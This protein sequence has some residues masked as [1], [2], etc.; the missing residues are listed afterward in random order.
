MQKIT[1]NKPKLLHKLN[2]KQASVKNLEESKLL[3]DKAEDAKLAKK[4][5]KDVEKQKKV[6][7]LAREKQIKRAQS[8]AEAQARMASVGPN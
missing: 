1:K 4:L 8:D 5:S 2:H 3:K 6:E 7:D